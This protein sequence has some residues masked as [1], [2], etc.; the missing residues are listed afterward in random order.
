MPTILYTLKLIFLIILSF[1]IC[2]AYLL[3]NDW[4][5]NKYVK[6][7]NPNITFYYNQCFL[8]F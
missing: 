8:V 5:E 4:L 2:W 7:L 6:A 1:N 3:Y